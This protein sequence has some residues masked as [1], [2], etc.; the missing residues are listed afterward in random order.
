MV[1]H[2][3]S[4]WGK[5]LEAVLSGMGIKDVIRMIWERREA[6]EIE[7]RIKIGLEKLKNETLR[8]EEDK[9]KASTYNIKYKFLVE[10]DNMP[11]KYWLEE[12]V[13]GRD[14]EIWARIRC[15]NIGRAGKKGELDW[16]CRICEEQDETF[17]H[18][19]MCKKSRELVTKKTREG[20]EVWMEEIEEGAIGGEVINMLG[21]KVQKEICAYV[22]E[23]EEV[24]NKRSGEARMERK[25]D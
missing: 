21:G 17:E 23:I 4:K 7:A 12:N 3:P 20:V 25:E 5:D 8:K 11:W 15:G 13:K 9:I 22:K 24:W 2:A 6:K 18:I 16:M 14:K 1:N 10:N 19:L